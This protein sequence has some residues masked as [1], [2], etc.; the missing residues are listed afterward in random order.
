[1]SRSDQFYLMD[2]RRDRC[3]LKTFESCLTTGA[4]EALR[5]SGGNITFVMLTHGGWLFRESIFPRKKRLFHRLRWLGHI[6]HMPD[7]C[8]LHTARYARQRM[9]KTQ[10]WAIPQITL[11]RPQTSY[12]RWLFASYSPLRP[13]TDGKDSGVVSPRPGMRDLASK[14]SR[15]GKWLSRMGRVKE[16][17]P[18]WM[19]ENTLFTSSFTPATD[20]KDS[21]VVSPRPGMRDLASKLS[22]VGKWLSRMGRV[23]ENK[24]M[25]DSY[26]QKSFRCSAVLIGQEAACPQ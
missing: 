9:E 22:R 11:A 25:I 10:G 18:M 21:G 26:L 12:A 5:E 19:S 13:A 20:G 8:L 6:L 23:K 24:P 14:L 16:N 15:V 3:V 4:S 2:R 7:G 17:K 1:M